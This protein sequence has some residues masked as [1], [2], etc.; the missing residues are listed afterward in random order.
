MPAKDIY[1]NVVKNALQ[2]QGWRITAEPFVLQFRDI[3]LYIDL[4]AEKII[5]ADKGADKIAVEVKSFIGKSNIYDLHLAVG[6]FIH[7]RMALATEDPQR[8]LY[9]AVPS[10]VYKDFFTRPFA[11][12]S[13]QTNQLK[14]IVYEI[15]HEEIM[16]WLT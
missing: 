12:A 14:L 15:T 7:Y 4:G 16:L 5:V 6:Q 1:H 10:E 3:D 11:Q 8:T 9:L 13:I 2:K